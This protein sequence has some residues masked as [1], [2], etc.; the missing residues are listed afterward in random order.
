MRNGAKMVTADSCVVSGIV[1]TTGGSVSCNNLTQ[2][3]ALPSKSSTVLAA[4]PAR[5]AVKVASNQTLPQA[6]SRFRADPQGPLVLASARWTVGQDKETFLPE[7]PDSQELQDLQDV[8]APATIQSFDVAQGELASEQASFGTSS[9]K[10]VA[11]SVETPVVSSAEIDDQ[12]EL[13][14]T[15]STAWRK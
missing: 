9:S 13:Q 8:V 3:A 5:L 12:K 15:A 7:Q 14:Q 4:G 6:D 10:P 1:D 2:S 11:S